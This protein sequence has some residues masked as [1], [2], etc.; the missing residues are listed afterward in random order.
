MNNQK[1]FRG[2]AVV[3][4]ENEV[5]NPNTMNL[6]LLIS[7]KNKDK[8]IENYWD[9]DELKYFVATF[10]LLNKYYE[11]T[12][13]V[14]I[15]VVNINDQ[16]TVEATWIPFFGDKTISQDD[17]SN[18]NVRFYILNKD[19]YN[20]PVSGKAKLGLMPNAN[21]LV[22]RFAKK[23]GQFYIIVSV[24]KIKFINKSTGFG[25]GGSGGGIQIPIT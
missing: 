20:N 2:S 11:N 4:N 3:A 22:A 6:N 16:N 1:I 18:P 9:G 24:T 15:R 10:A 21:A 25:N 12:N 13:E 5:H 14:A 8:A 17:N 7:Q 19:D 23:E